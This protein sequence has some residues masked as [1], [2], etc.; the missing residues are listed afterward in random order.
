MQVITGWQSRSYQWDACSWL[1][2]RALIRAILQ[3]GSLADRANDRGQTPADNMIEWFDVPANYRGARE[4]QGT[5]D[6][7][8]DLL[9]SGGFM[10][11]MGLNFRHRPIC[12]DPFYHFDRGYGCMNDYNFFEDSS[13]R[14][15]WQI[16]DE[17]EVQG[18]ILAMKEIKQEAMLI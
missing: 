15:I 8:S 6:I 9:N 17:K 11:H 5:I 2:W 12:V 7:C 3:I 13:I 1:R 18:R 14:L 10:T 4:R 16:A